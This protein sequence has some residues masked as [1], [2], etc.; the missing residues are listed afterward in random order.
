MKRVVKIK[1]LKEYRFFSNFSWNE[2]NCNL[3]TKYNII[4]GWNGSGKT[5]ICDFFRDLEQRK[6]SEDRAKFSVLLGDTASGKTSEVTHN[7]IGEIPCSFRVFYQDYIQ[8]NISEIDHVRHIY[9]VGKG[10][11]EKAVELKELQAEKKRLEGVV[12]DLQT[13]LLQSENN[14]DRIKIATAKIIKEAAGY[15]SGYNK[16][17]FYSA[18]EKEPTLKKLSDSEFEKARIAVRAEKRQPIQIIK[19][20]F[21]KPTVKTYLSSILDETPANVAIES[22]EKDSELSRWVETGLYIHDTRDSSICL[23]CGHEITT[24]RFD[25]LRA[26]FNDAYKNL[27]EKIDTSIALLHQKEQ[28]FEQAKIALPDMAVFYPELQEQYAPL[29]AEAEKLCNTY[30]A[31]IKDVITV[32]ESKKTDMVSQEY[33][34]A[35]LS[36]L[37]P[38]SFDYTLFEKIQSVIATHNK[39]SEDYQRSIE[40]AQKSIEHHIMAEHK[41]E[42]DKAKSDIAKKRKELSVQSEILTQI[43]KKT[44]SMQQEVRNSQIP[45]TAI[46]DDIKSIM[47]RAEIA[48]ENTPTGY[49]IT[50]NGKLAKNLSKGEENA[51]ALIYFFNTLLD[52]NADSQNTIIVLDDPISSFDSNFYYNAM[53]YIREKSGNIGQ[54]FVF[55]HKFSLFNDYGR[56]YPGDDTNRYI[57]RRIGEGP[58]I[59]NEDKHLIGFHDEYAFLFK[60]VYDFAK[61]PPEDISEYLQYPNMARRLLEGFLTFKCPDPKLDMINR[62]LQL[63]K[64]KVTATSRAVLRLVNNK[65]HMRVIPDGDA[66]DDLDNITAMPEIIKN[67]LEFMKAHDEMHYSILAESCDSDYRADGPAI[68]IRAVIPRKIKLYDMPASAGFGEKIDN[69]V[70]YEEISVSDTKCTFAVKISGDSMEPKYPD[71]SIAL[72]KQCDALDNARI[73]IVW[74]NDKSYCK[75]VVHANGKTLLV[76]LNKKYAAITVESA[77]FRI[78]GEVVGSIV[79]Q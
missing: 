72:V 20:D 49:R 43:S 74:Y 56:M 59:E 11:K 46:N 21:I 61:N 30:I 6:L 60:K 77:D 8:E 47:G 45:A 67:M 76:S 2:G 31:A 63:E 40:V 33:K 65:S 3:F 75:K 66:V 13:A 79:Q 53:S 29:K 17:A 16:N 35:L 12:N 52:S 58:S 69:D 14:L 42:L 28:E 36:V 62:V 70:P 22:L 73:G 25:A 39:K 38:L 71:K 68:G 55:T 57:I 7:G 44:E 1:T 24:T 4:Y 48:F 32:M 64:G 23:F 51:V 27:M 15:S 54:V 78:F 18:F 34:Q 19:A 26:H 37:A 5:T 10:Q 41:E 50:R 9:A